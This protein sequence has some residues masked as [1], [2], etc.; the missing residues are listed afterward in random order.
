MTN[1]E[2]LATPSNT[3]ISIEFP[4][5][6]EKVISIGTL[7]D[8]QYQVQRAKVPVPVIGSKIPITIARG[9]RTIAGN[10]TGVVLEKSFQFKLIAYFW[11][12]QEEQKATYREPVVHRISGKQE[13]EDIYGTIENFLNNVAAPILQTLGFS[14]PSDLVQAFGLDGNRQA[15]LSPQPVQL[16]E[17]A[18]LPPIY[19][20]EIPPIKLILVTPVEYLRD[21]NNSTIGMRYEK[22]I[23]HGLEF[24]N[25]D[26]AVSAGREAIFESVNFIARSVSRTLEEAYF[27]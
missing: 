23:F 2:V 5:P 25:N 12:V 8:F 1:R 3:I 22:I 6:V 24:L 13:L 15:Q 9:A 14:N 7:Q 21:D 20:D 27:G 19:L 10:M 16:T 11:Y 4:K 17:Y 26:Y 18:K